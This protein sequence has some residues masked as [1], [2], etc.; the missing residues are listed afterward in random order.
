LLL[1]HVTGVGRITHE[2]TKTTKTTQD[3]GQLNVEGRPDRKYRELD[4]QKAFGAT[5]VFFLLTF[6]R[7]SDF[8]RYERRQ[9]PEYVARCAAA[10]LCALQM[11]IYGRWRGSWELITSFSHFNTRS[12][13]HTRGLGGHVLKEAWFPQSHELH[14]LLRPRAPL[15][16]F[17][18]CS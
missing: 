15:Q 17:V 6:P 16:D 5:G 9:P 10:V 8:L 3:Q 14:V 11:T 12:Q 4:G 7:R 2:T 13:S 18:R 1:S